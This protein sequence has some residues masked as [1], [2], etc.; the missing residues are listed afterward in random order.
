M[1]SYIVQVRV[2]CTHDYFIRLGFFSFFFFF[3]VINKLNKTKINKYLLSEIIIPF[4]K[5]L[6]S[7]VV[8][9]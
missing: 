8:T 2:Q 1:S 6:I 9:Q 7:L 5:K 3:F 4:Y